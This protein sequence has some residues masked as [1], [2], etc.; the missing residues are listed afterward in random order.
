MLPRRVTE[1][2]TT[3]SFEGIRDAFCGRLRNERVHLVALSAALVGRG[4][5]A[6]IV[7]DLRDRAHRL[8]GAAAIFALADI[9]RAAR[10]LERAAAA[11]QTSRSNKTDAGV[12]DALTA[13]VG[14]IDGLRRRATPVQVSR[15]ASSGS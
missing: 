6:S 7:D 12:R 11:A 10:C 5:D 13:L 4:G 8:S 15:G 9:A 1:K 14:L 3:A 2:S